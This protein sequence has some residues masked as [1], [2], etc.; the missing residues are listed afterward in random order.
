[1]RSIYVFWL[2][3]LLLVFATF[4]A[5]RWSNL[6]LFDFDGGGYYA[7]LPSAFIYHDLGRADWIETKQQHYRPGTHHSIGIT[8]LPNG[9]VVPK[10]PMGVAVG[11][12]PWFVAAHWYAPVAGFAA[13][14]FTRPYQRAMVL[15]GLA[16]GLLGL[17]VVRKL[18]LRYF[19]DGVTAWALAGVGLGTNFF[20]YAS[21]EANMSHAPL[22]LWH[23][24]LLYC[25][26]LWYH[27]FRWRYA[28]GLGLFMGLICLTRFSEALYALIPLL[29]GIQRAADVPLRL[30]AWWQHRSQVLVAVV[31]AAAVLSLQLVFW[32]ATSGHW[33]LDTYVGERFDFAHPH[34]LDGLFSFR[35]GW[36][37]YTPMMALA[38]LGWLV[39]RRYV[40]AAWLPTLAVLPVAWYIT[41]SWGQWW[42]GGGFSARPLISLYPLL[43]LSLASLVAYVGAHYR[44]WRPVLRGLMVVFILLN[45]LQT[46]QY[47]HGILHWDSNTRELY[48]RN[49]FA[50]RRDQMWLPPGQPNPSAAP[51]D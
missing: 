20:C 41:F 5:R 34:I 46:W 39:L 45:F 8:P 37:L 7:Y 50:V 49:F 13:D 40:P 19:S 30:H 47:R 32:R 9:N 43:A 15:A 35:K 23:A 27:T 29:W 12:L 44:P 6:A 1:M 14:G 3:A 26:V 33:L 31:L 22:F 24:S 4:Q 17:W 2:T 28:V 10:Y 11:A 42:Y 36:L 16:Y 51:R 25:T 38:L 18:L 21:Y 48:M